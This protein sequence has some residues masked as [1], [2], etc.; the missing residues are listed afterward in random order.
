MEQMILTA[1]GPSRPDIKGVA[2]IPGEHGWLCSITRMTGSVGPIGAADRKLMEFLKLYVV[3]DA[4]GRELDGKL[5]G[6]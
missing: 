2:L 3:V 1:L 6:Q 5:S 4:E